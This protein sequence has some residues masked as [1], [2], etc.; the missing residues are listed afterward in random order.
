MPAPRVELLDR[1]HEA[2]RALLDEVGEREPVLGALEGAGDV[3][4]EAKVRL[5]HPLLGVEVAA[6]HAQREPALLRRRQQRHAAH[7][8][9]E[10]GE[11]GVVG[12]VAH[13]RAAS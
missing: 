10:V 11:A 13:R 9:E 1:A 2:E 8:G 4:D 7:L 5:D 3:D 6:L 12:H